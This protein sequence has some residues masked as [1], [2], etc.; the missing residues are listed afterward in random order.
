MSRYEYKVVP[1]PRRPLKARGVKAMPDRFA[2]A[3][4]GAMNELGAQ[5]WEYQRSDALPCEAGGGWFR[6]PSTE[7]QWV[8]VFRR[9]VAGSRT[10]ASG[11]P[12][13]PAANPA[14]DGF[15]ASDRPVFEHAP[16]RRAPTSLALGEA[17]QARREPAPA[18]AATVAAPPHRPDP[19]GPRSDV[20]IGGVRRDHPEPDTAP[21]GVHPFPGPARG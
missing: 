21:S 12:G 6:R 13:S 15:P 4:A 14:E 10:S 20:R 1:A 17:E 9:S 7:T 5:G 2:L 18:P 19:A 16:V 3:V 8:L 11:T